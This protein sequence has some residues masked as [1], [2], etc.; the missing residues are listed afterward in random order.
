MCIY[1]LGVIEI[2]PFFAKI[3]SSLLY[4][5]FKLIKGTIRYQAKGQIRYCQSKF[6]FCLGTYK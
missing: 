5:C 6:L 4:L 3:P 1:T 2:A